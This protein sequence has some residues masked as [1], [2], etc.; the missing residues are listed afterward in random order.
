MEESRVLLRTRFSKQGLY[1]KTVLIKKEKNTE[2]GVVPE[3]KK[4]AN[5]KELRSGQKQQASRH[6][7]H[8]G[9][10][11]ALE[12]HSER[13]TSSQKFMNLFLVCVCFKLGNFVVLRAIHTF[14]SPQH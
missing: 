11:M 7:F 3:N 2:V 12:A 4:G 1:H 13:C 14:S 9:L 8:V 10:C 6:T 5:L